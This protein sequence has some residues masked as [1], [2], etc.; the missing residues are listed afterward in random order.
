MRINWQKWLIRAA[1]LAVIALIVGAFILGRWTM[2]S[3][4]SVA[5]AAAQTDDPESDAGEVKVQM[6][7]CSMHPSF[8]T[9]NPSDICPICAMELIPVP[10]DGDEDDDGVVRLRLSPRAVALMNVQVWPAERR[11]VENE[12]RLYGQIDF[13]ETRLRTIAAWVPGR[14]DRLHV[15]FTGTP[16][17]RGEPMVEVYSPQLVAAQQELLQAARAFE[18]LHA[19]GAP[20]RA[21]DMA[22]STLASSRERLRLLGLDQNQI[23]EVERAGMV[24][25]HITIHAPSD[26]IVIERHA[27]EG[28]YVETGEAVYTLADLSTVWV[29]LEVYEQDLTWLRVGQPARF[30]AQ[31][32]PGETFDGEVVFIDPVLDPQRRTAR[33]RVELPNP[34]GRLKPGMFVRGTV[35]AALDEEGRAVSP[36]IN[37][38]SG[39]VQPPLVIPATAPLH[40]GR[41]AV[42][43]V[44]VPG[45]ER[46]TFEPRD[47][48][49]GPR[50]GNRYIVRSGL[51][52]GD[53]VVVNGQFKIDSELQIRGR[54]S[55]MQPEGGPPPGL[56]DHGDPGH[57]APT[58]RRTP[59]LDVPEDF[60]TSLL[61]VY[62]HYIALQTGLAD[63]ELETALAAAAQMHQAVAALD[64]GV[65]SREAADAWRV[66]AARLRRD[67]ASV[68]HIDDIERLRQIF[69][70]YSDA[71]IEMARRFGY[72][73]DEHLV[74]AYCP[75]TFDD[76]GSHWLQVG[77]AITNPYFGASMYRCGDVRE[78]IGHSDQSAPA[79]QPAE[80]CPLSG[81]APA[82]ATKPEDDS[83]LDEPAADGPAEF[84]AAIEP[85]YAAY[86]D[87]QEALAADQFERSREA[88][89]RLHAQ[90]NDVDAQLAGERAHAWH[91]I[92]SR[93]LKNAEHTDRAEMERLRELFE[94]W[95]AAA[96]DL[97]KSFGHAGEHNHYVIHCPMAFDWRGA[98]WLQRD[99]TVNNP[100]FGS[101]MLR[102]GS[103]RDRLAPHN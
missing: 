83:P 99:G 4:E 8:R 97:S 63:D 44:N 95:A 14:L 19:N 58:A 45:E 23:D 29:Q 51:R 96:I 64:A 15:N 47:V 18:Q 28:V 41:R 5:V 27:T 74:V 31:A 48:V 60:R 89:K 50:T 85:V 75:M 6:Y 56:H 53:L 67:H 70:G 72:A 81:A 87:L 20:G 37:M 91:A 90:V 25:T 93:M 49:L 65:L 103:V 55:M 98:D 16:V 92:A 39:D 66:I 12:V 3:D 7:T 42:V 100:Y 46:P 88:A 71:A 10:D 79:P 32:H 62:E 57:H 17:A 40:T 82:V 13:D 35:R 84:I 30:A 1:W 54:P 78:H 94:A 22:E 101:R 11:F 80:C 69:E 24:Q 34:G 43:Y 2:R 26:G 59:T 38:A 9:P 77:N 21:A 33:V 76:K 36:E 52:E 73:G 68:A 86:F 61:P 102:C